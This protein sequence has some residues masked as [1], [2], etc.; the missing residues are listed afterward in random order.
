[1]IV[2]IVVRV[3]MVMVVMV[4][5]G[6]VVVVVFVVLFGVPQH[7]Y[8]MSLPL[9]PPCPDFL[10]TWVLEIKP[11]SS[12]LQDKCFSTEQSPHIFSYF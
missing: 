8:H 5:V 11:M 12:C 1:M 6:V 10:K 7:Q 9:Q 3:M 4:A 2:V